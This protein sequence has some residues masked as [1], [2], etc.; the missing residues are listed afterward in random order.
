MFLSLVGIKKL[1]II[2]VDVCKRDLRAMSIG[3]ITRE[4]LTSERATWRQVVQKGLLKFDE[5]LAQHSE[6]KRPRRKVQNQ[7]DR[8]ALVFTSSQCGKDCHSRIGSSNHTRRCI[9]FDMWQLK[10][11]YL[12]EPV[13][14]PD[15]IMPGQKIAKENELAP[16]LMK[17]IKRNVFPKALSYMALVN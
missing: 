4:A 12:N 6:A 3:L 9:G 1:I 11:R 14:P 5:T 15:V 8:P 7:T 13:T 2:F 10:H 17:T 16:W